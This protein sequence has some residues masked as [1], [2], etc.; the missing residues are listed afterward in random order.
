MNEFLIGRPAEGEA[1][2]S[3]LIVSISFM[4]QLVSPLADGLSLP[5][6]ATTGEPMAH[7]ACHT[8]HA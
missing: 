1:R 2:R 8:I 7:C 3:E 6:W 5:Q 4:E